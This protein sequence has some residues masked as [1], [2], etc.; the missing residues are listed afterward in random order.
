MSFLY[1]GALVKALAVC[2]RRPYIQI[3]KVSSTTCP[4]YQPTDGQSF[5]QPILLLALEDYFHEPT[6]T[7]LKRMYEAINSID[8][9]LAPSL[10]LDERM[11][12]RCSERR[13]LFE[14]KF[15]TAEDNPLS[16]SAMTTATISTED[17]PSHLGVPGGDPDQQPRSRVA[18][19]NS[20]ASVAGAARSNSGKLVTTNGAKS[21][22]L[23]DTHY[24]ETSVYYNDLSLPIRVPLY[25]FPDEV[26]D[27]SETF[28]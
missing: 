2:S 23:R 17:R 22:S 15:N 12:L 10:S 7:V 16:P 6:P 14:E 13:D 21:K 20:N 26:G 4:S 1:R 3:F 24:F 5:S 18:S 11:V 19:D 25:T 27:V 8:T 28:R 9:A